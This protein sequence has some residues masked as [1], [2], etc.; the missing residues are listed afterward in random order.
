MQLSGAVG[1]D[2][3]LITNLDLAAHPRW[4]PKDLGVQA[5]PPVLVEQKECFHGLCLPGELPWYLAGSS[6]ISCVHRQPLQD[7]VGQVVFLQSEQQPGSL[8]CWSSFPNLQIRLNTR[9][10][11]I[12]M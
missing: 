7:G 5:C 9:E 1:A 3:C 6:W 4:A 2:G 10:N 12:K 8:L 11:T